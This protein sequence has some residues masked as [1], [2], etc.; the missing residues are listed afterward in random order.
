VLVAGW[1]RLY[2]CTVRWP[3]AASTTTLAWRQT[4]TCRL[5]PVS[6]GARLLVPWLSA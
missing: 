4:R 2:D 3:P 1:A 5:P 6:R